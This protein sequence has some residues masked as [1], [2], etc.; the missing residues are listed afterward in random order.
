M[1]IE[2]KINSSWKLYYKKGSWMSYSF[3]IFLK[4]ANYYNLLE[5]RSLSNLNN[6]TLVCDLSPYRCPEMCTHTHKRTMYPYP[7]LNKIMS[8]RYCTRLVAHTIHCLFSKLKNWNRD[9]KLRFQFKR[10]CNRSCVLD[11]T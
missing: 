5:V 7:Y 4:L 6:P 11:T 2:H 10:L 3:N 1:R 9:F 8:V